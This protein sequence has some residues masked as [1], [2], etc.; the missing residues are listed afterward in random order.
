MDFLIIKYQI[1]KQKKTGK[2]LKPAAP[3]DGT[4]TKYKFESIFLGD[5]Y[6]SVVNRANLKA[7]QITKNNEPLHP[8]EPI[9]KVLHRYIKTPGA[10]PK[11]ITSLKESN[12]APKLDP[13]PLNFFANQP[14]KKSNIAAK[15]IS[16]IA[17]SHSFEIENLIDDNPLHKDS[18]VMAFG[19]YLARKF[20]FFSIFI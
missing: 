12:S 6:I 1:Q 14:S 4:P 18:N 7:E 17:I 20:E 19:T 16:K 10:T 13:S 15:T 3:G 2:R 5:K 11:E 9:S 8:R